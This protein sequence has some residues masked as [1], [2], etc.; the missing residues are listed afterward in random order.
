LA[1][2]WTATTHARNLDWLANFRRAHSRQGMPAFSRP[3]SALD[4][5]EYMVSARDAID[6]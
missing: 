5:D 1:T 2:L 3:R 4:E 6:R